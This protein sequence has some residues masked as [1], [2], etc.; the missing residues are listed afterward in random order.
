MG[1]M[2]WLRNFG[3]GLLVMAAFIGPGTVT[4][5]SLAGAKYGYVLLWAVLFSI[6]ATMVLQEMA[7]R[8]GL[9]TREGL[10][11]NL[12]VRHC[13]YPESLPT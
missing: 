9:V 13:R 1:R 6:L 8:L 7:Y 11:T 5:A 2:K 10:G 4:M 12:Q 3:P